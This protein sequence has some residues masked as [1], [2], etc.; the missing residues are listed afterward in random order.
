MAGH[1]KLLIALR[2][3]GEEPLPAVKTRVVPLAQL[4]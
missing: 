4:A 2:W 3:R 1:A